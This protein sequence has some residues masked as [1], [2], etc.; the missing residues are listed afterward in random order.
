MNEIISFL[1]SDTIKVVVT[2]ISSAVGILLTITKIKTMLPRPRLYLKE[3]IEILKSL[4]KDQAE[5]KIVSEYIQNKIRV[6]YSS[7]EEDRSFFASNKILSKILGAMMVFSGVYLTYVVHESESWKAWWYIGTIYLAILGFGIMSI[8]NIRK[9]RLQTPPDKVQ[10]D[11][12][13][14]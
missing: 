6:V 9:G 3:D 4:D 11:D 13:Q 14:K 1:G 10:E 5:Y 7:Q 8:T 12:E 2:V